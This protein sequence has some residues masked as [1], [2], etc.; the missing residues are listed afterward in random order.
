VNISKGNAVYQFK[1]ADGAQQALVALQNSLKHLQ[2]SLVDLGEY[3]GRTDDQD[4]GTGGYDPSKVRTGYQD[5]GGGSGGRGHG[6]ETYSYRDSYRDRR[7]DR[8]PYD[9]FSR[10]PYNDHRYDD[11]RYDTNS[12]RNDDTTRRPYNRDDDSRRFNTNDV[13]RNDRS[14]DKPYN[15]HG[16]SHFFIFL[17]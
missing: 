11:R 8:P 9:S 4:R 5:R 12:R 7:D 3:H 17:L 13:N 1:Y 2:A 16:E 10:P 14:A 15:R 6:R